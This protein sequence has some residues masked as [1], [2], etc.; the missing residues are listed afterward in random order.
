MAMVQRNPPPELIVHSDRG[1]HWYRKATE[2]GYFHAQEALADLHHRSQ[3][4]G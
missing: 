4:N 3:L 2:L 1:T